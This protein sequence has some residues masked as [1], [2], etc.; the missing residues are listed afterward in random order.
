MILEVLDEL[1]IFFIGDEMDWIIA[2]GLKIV[3]T[4]KFYGYL[5]V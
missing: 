1:G 5:H 2:V 3:D 4:G